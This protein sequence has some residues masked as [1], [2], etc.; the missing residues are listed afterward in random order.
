[1]DSNLYFSEITNNYI[2]EF[3]ELVTYEILKL[4]T[5]MFEYCNNN[6]SHQKPYKILN[7]FISLF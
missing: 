6:V 2:L 4:V 7:F 3:W 1:M 5:W